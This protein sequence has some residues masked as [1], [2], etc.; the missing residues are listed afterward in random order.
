[1]IFKIRKIEKNE[2]VA[3]IARI[4]ETARPHV[5][6]MSRED[7]E[8]LGNWRKA[9][10]EDY[11]RALRERAALGGDDIFEIVKTALSPMAHVKTLVAAASLIALLFTVC[12]HE[13]PNSRSPQKSQIIPIEESVT[14][15]VKERSGGEDGRL[16]TFFEERAIARDAKAIPKA[17]LY[18]CR[19]SVNRIGE[20][21]KATVAA[22][23]LLSSFTD[24]ERRRAC[25]EFAD[26]VGREPADL[27]R[28]LEEVFA[29]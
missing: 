10:R 12:V 14:D 15:F 26:T 23:H 7:F 16:A 13:S 9:I 29:P 3:L 4:S 8:S 19:S 22:K 27:L 17:I 20:Q 2:R 21:R 25:V 18:A 5:W 1:M 11:E 24:S 28:R 6:E